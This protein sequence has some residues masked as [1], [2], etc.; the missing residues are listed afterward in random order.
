MELGGGPGFMVASCTGHNRWSV[1]ATFLE[2]RHD[3]CGGNADVFDDAWI[4]FQGSGHLGGDFSV[5][6]FFG[7]PWSDPR[8]CG[9]YS[10]LI[11]KD[12]Q[13]TFHAT[14]SDRD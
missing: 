6:S 2:P 12:R 11:Y 8:F 9:A 7:A 5:A 4:T 14:I 3:V 13:Q 1:T 10:E